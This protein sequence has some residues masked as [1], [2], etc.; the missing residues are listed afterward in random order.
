MSNFVETW[1][2]IATALGRS[3]RWCRYMAR[4]GADPLPVFKVGGIV[5]LNSNDLEDWL[6]ESFLMKRSFRNC[7]LIAGLIE[8]RFPGAEKSGRQVTFSADLIYDVL[9][10]Y[11]PDHLLLSCARTDAAN[12]LLD[13]GRLGEF[14]ARIK[15]RIRL[16]R[17]DHVSPFAVPIMMEIGRERAPGTSAADLILE[18]AA[19]DLDLISEAMA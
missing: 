16:Q 18:S 2:G 7:A 14:L 4:R 12:G 1:K 9:R 17:L 10:R 8:R 5:R 19:E 13:I 3:E 11:Q 15:E 6:A